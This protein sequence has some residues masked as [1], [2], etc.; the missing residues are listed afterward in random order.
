MFHS[1]RS[2]WFVPTMRQSRQTRL[3]LSYRVPDPAAGRKICLFHVQLCWTWY[4]YVKPLPMPAIGGEGSK[5]RKESGDVTIG[6]YGM[7]TRIQLTVTTIVYFFIGCILVGD[8][9][10]NYIPASIV[11]LVGIAYI[12]LEFVPSIEPPANMR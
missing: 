9:W 5:R 4:L 6:F 8:R 3:M 10:F 12:V 1:Y 2:A 7:N 11:A